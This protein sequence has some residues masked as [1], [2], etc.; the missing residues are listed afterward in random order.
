[1]VKAELARMN[2]YFAYWSATVHIPL[3]SCESV[4]ADATLYLALLAAM[5]DT[6]VKLAGNDVRPVKFTLAFRPDVPLPP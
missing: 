3:A 5:V 6:D 1:V 4:A 2:R